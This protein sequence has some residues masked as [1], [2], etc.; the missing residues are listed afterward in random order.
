MMRKTNKIGI[1]AAALMVAG[2]AYAGNPQRA[3]SAGASELLINPWA[4]TSGWASTNIA[5]VKGVQASFLNIAGTAQT[6]RTSVAFNNTQ[7]L[8]G[9][10]VNI[11]AFGFTQKVGGSGV[12]GANITAFDYGKIERTT[13]SN[14]DGGIGYF[15]PSTVNIG[16]SY[17]QRFTE[18]ILGG[19]NVKLYSQSTQ[20]LSVNA[21][22]F[23]AGVQ[24]IAGEND[25]IKFGITLQNVGPSTSFEG[26][27]KSVVLTVPTGT[28]TQAYNER[29]ADFELPTTLSIGGSYD[30]EFTSQRLTLAAAYQ[31][32]SFQKDE[33]RLGAEYSFN[34]LVMARAGY[35]LFDN[36]VNGTTTAA[37]SG[38]TAGLS[39][40]V[41]LGDSKFM[42][43][44]SYMTTN[45]FD[46]IHSMGVSFDL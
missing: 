41:P 12:L 31:S 45:W 46:G 43:D 3:G 37:I 23:D 18:S 34:D 21:L 4:R 6:E 10:D 36:R 29:S 9:T 24:Y 44:Y 11:N 26:D 15:E 28:Y 13:G 16:V 38:L 42:L 39:V 7:W 30:W 17:A 40:D 2:Q 8:V 14:P 27:G 20:N 19:V 5:G 33:Y 1:L 35:I 25:Q 32:N 22:C